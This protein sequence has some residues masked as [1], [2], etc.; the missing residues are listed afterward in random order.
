V[1]S[2]EKMQSQN[3]SL[4][5]Q[6]DATYD[7]TMTGLLSHLYPPEPYQEF[8]CLCLRTSVLQTTVVPTDLCTHKT[9]IW[10]ITWQS[11]QADLWNCRDISWTWQSVWVYPQNCR[12]IFTIFFLKGSMTICASSRS[13]QDAVPTY[14]RS[15]QSCVLNS[16]TTNITRQA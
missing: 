3:H 14:L 12:E 6:R 10:K 9:T 15:E 11:M 7:N 1:V 4:E 13:F 5:P 8:T 16:K 2:S